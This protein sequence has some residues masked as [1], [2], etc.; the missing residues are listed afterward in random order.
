MKL[1]EKVKAV[2]DIGHEKTLEVARAHL[3][4]HNLA[5]LVGEKEIVDKA[6]FNEDIIV[7]RH[8]VCYQIERRR[9]LSVI[10]ELIGHNSKKTN[11]IPNL[12]YL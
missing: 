10:E 9:Y 5:D 8:G 11:N 2:P 1:F 6:G 4:R 12:L 3:E 7:R